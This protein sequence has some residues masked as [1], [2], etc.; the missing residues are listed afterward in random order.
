MKLKV[1]LELLPRPVFLVFLQAQVQELC[2][3]EH[4]LDL[5][6]HP[7]FNRNQQLNLEHYPPLHTNQQL[8]LGHLVLK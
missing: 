4:Q 7:P 1:K 3:E 8:D 2:S 6:H 5:E